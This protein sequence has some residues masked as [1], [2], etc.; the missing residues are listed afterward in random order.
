MFIRSRGGVGLHSTASHTIWHSWG[1]YTC[2]FFRG[3]I[4]L[5]VPHTLL[6]RVLA[7]IACCF[8]PFFF[9]VLSRKDTA[10]F[11]VWPASVRRGRGEYS[12]LVS[13]QRFSRRICITI[14]CLGCCLWVKRLSA[15]TIHPSPR[16]VHHLPLQEDESP[17]QMYLAPPV[18]HFPSAPN[19]AFPVD[20]GRR[21][22]PSPSLEA[23]ERPTHASPE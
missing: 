5:F 18:R 16:H 23:P 15:Q 1:I 4:L 6:C 17:S 9:Y 3:D 2:I 13:W 7:S 11:G 10:I 19:V 12:V 8:L 14:A 20:W 21:S 22:L